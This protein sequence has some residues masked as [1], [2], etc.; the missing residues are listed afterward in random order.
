MQQVPYPT[1]EQLARIGEAVGA[2]TLRF[3]ERLDA[4]MSCVLDVLSD[5]TGRVVLR[6]YGAWYVER[7]EDPA[8][9]EARALELMQRV[10]VP[11]PAPLW[12][13]NGDLFD[14]PALVVSY[15]DGDPD[16]APGHPFDWAEQLAAVLARIHGVAVEGSDVELFGPGIGEDARR[17][18]EAPEQIL[19]HPLGEALLRRMFELQARL[20]EVAPVFSHADFWPGNT[21]WNGGK[22]AAVVDW[23]APATSDP[24]MDVAYCATDIRLL[25]MGRVADRFVAAYREITGDRLVNLAYWEAVALSRPMPD[26]AVWVPTWTA[27]GRPIGTDAARAAHIRAIEEFLDRT[28]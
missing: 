25:G 15:V 12:I 19:E 23:E 27:L 11:A 17:I 7:G 16:L 2:G 22:L 14:R 6:R 10:R 8:A 28:A 5:G 24:A 13:P 21:L 20:L 1:D 4:G 26:I 9:R 18:E 3:V